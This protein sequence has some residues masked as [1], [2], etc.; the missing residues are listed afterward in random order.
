MDSTIARNNHIEAGDV[1]RLSLLTQHKMLNLTFKI[2]HSSEDRDFMSLL[3]CGSLQFANK[4]D[5]FKGTYRRTKFRIFALVQQN[6]KKRGIC[7]LT[8]A[9]WPIFSEKRQ[10]RKMAKPNLHDSFYFF[11]LLFTSAVRFFNTI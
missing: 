9:P 11:T 5:C 4:S 3:P 10:I 2:A 8:Q 6:I 7:L 1:S